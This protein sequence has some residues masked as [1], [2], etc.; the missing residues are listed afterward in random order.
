MATS[1]PDGGDPER[2]TR[3]EPRTIQEPPSIKSPERSWVG[4]GLLFV[5]S[6]AVAVGVALATD[7]PA[8]SGFV[9]GAA[10]LAFV[11]GIAVGVERIIEVAWAQVDRN[12]ERGAWWPL[13]LVTDALTEVET[14]T[15]EVLTPFVSNVGNLL[16]DLDGWVGDTAAKQ[17]AVTSVATQ[18][19]ERTDATRK[20]IANAQQLAPGS[21]RFAA[22]ARATDD[23]THDAELIARRAGVWSR[24]LERHLRAASDALSSAQDVVGAFKDNP[25]RK[26]M[27]IAL[28]VPLAILA[29]GV[30]GLNM[31]SAV[32]G[33]DVPG[34]MA[35]L[36]GILATGV[37]MGLGSSPTH[38]VI[39]ALQRR[40]GDAT[41]DVPVA[42]SVRVVE[43]EVPVGRET[44]TTPAVTEH[45]AGLDSF[46][47]DTVRNLIAVREFMTSPT[48]PTM[49][50]TTF[51]SNRQ[52]R[53]IRNAG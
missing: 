17:A 53:P 43:T 30:L 20:A 6:I 2:N 15:N 47:A 23:F 22:I 38:E 27:S 10:V 45:V 36:A 33:P 25:A 42:S 34:Y 12:K 16:V 24:D 8:N 50:R 28:G 4:I 19:E 9:D 11:S 52:V 46:D 49:V 41:I 14:K 3:K 40:K 35:G 32:L 1:N 18:I 29:S 5:V 31:F 26:T 48:P 51:V 44:P 21:S 37:V 7:E 13:S 39:K